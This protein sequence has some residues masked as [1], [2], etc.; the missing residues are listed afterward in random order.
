M[1]LDS[2]WAG[3][4]LAHSEFG[5][6]VDPIPT[7][8]S[9]YA[10]KTTACPPEIENLATPKQSNKFIGNGKNHQIRSSFKNLMQ[11][12]YGGRGEDGCSEGVGRRAGEKIQ[13][14]VGQKKFIR[15]KISCFLV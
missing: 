7:R 3:W 1:P 14:P 12:L 10:L 5:S 15:F 11:S 4:A 9:D 13:L 8:G 2:G 6:S